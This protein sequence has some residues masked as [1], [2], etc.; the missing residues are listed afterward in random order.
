MIYPNLNVQP[1]P[2]VQGYT[3]RHRVEPILPSQR[4]RDCTQEKVLWNGDEESVKKKQTEFLEEH[5]QEAPESTA[6]AKTICLENLLYQICLMQRCSTQSSSC[7][8]TL[9]T[10]TAWKRHSILTTYKSQEQLIVS[11]SSK[12]NCLS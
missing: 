12:V 10:F 1:L 2:M 4:L 7:L 3:R 8:T 9:T 11:E 6:T 5:L